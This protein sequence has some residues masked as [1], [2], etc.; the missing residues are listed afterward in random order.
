MKPLVF[1]A[2]IVLTFSHSARASDKSEIRVAVPAGFAPPLVFEKPGKME[3]LVVDYVNALAEAMGRKASYSIVTRYRLVGYMLKGQVDVL[4]Y[5]SPKWD[6]NTDTMDYSKT[7]FTKREILVGPAPLPKKISG[8]Q[9]KTIGAMLQY[10]YPTLDPYFQSGKLKREDSFSEHANLKKLLNGRIQYIVTDQIF[11]DY[12]RLENPTI[13]KNRET[14]FLEEY[15]IF[16]SISRQG[17]VKKKDLDRA[18]D[19]IKSSGKLEALFKK[20]GSSYI[21]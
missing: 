7:I 13:M 16:C 17:R 6:H 5:T 19:E 9:G 2:L 14:L 21:D 20:Y 10:V 1:I 12:F 3:G 18:I 8:L 4:C 15:P 11:L